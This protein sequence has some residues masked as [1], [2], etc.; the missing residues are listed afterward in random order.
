MAMSRIL[1]PRS[2]LYMPASNLRAIAKAR[3]L[4]C[5]MIIL[6]CEDAVPAG[7]KDEARAAAV[8]AAET[9]FGERLCAIRINGVD[10]TE[11]AAD[12]VAVRQS[13]ADFVVVPK[14]ENAALAEELAEKCGKPLL[15]M[16]ETPL[17]VLNAP[18]IATALDVAGLIAGTNDLAATLRLPPSDDRSGL[19]LSL[20]TIV[21][22][23]RSAE[24]WAF[25]G[26]CNDLSDSARLEIECHE[27]RNFGFDG[28][29]L[30]HP[31]QIKA[32]NRIWS[33]T[34]ADVEDAI[35]LVA[36]AKG[37]AERFRDRMIE[38]MHVE[39]AERLLARAAA[40]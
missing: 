26:V 11:H 22:S 3:D 10:T 1:A 35:A 8:D 5:D 28:K 16:I 34:N 31:N 29:T 21:L 25:D 18:A 6:D 37:G 9:G 15:A 32:T 33:P 20:Q 14:V 7:L 2:A 17:G 36:A 12:I 40:R 39:M 30:I 38:T 4:A 19:A 23:A 24:I 27:G 13:R